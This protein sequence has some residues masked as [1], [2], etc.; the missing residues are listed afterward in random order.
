M[1]AIANTDVGK[2]LSD[3]H[4]QIYG[5]ENVGGNLSSNNH[6]PAGNAPIGYAYTPNTVQNDQTVLFIERTPDTV[7]R[8]HVD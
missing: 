3:W 8:D 6:R 7:Q 2:F 1:V 4:V 5:S